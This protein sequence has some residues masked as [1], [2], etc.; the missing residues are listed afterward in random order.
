[1]KEASKAGVNVGE[2][3]PDFALPDGEGRT[4]R[5]SEHRGETIVLLFYPGDNTPVCTKQMCSVRDKWSDYVST[6]ASIVGISTDT[7]ESH[8][9]FAAKHGLPFPLLADPQEEVIRA[10]GVR[11]WLPHRSAR[12]VVVI[13]RDGVVTYKKVQ[14]LSLFPPRDD[15]IIAAIKEAAAGDK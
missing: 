7:V 15:R 8:K 11:S 12:A 1:M 2:R 14:P 4:W 10:Y 9:G 3:A 5:L 6:G 13:N